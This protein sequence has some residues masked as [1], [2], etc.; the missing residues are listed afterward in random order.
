MTDD[1]AHSLLPA[2]YALIKWRD[3]RAAI[4]D[5]IDTAPHE[6]QGIP[7]DIARRFTDAE[8]KLFEEACGL[9]WFEPRPAPK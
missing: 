9:N 7:S 1:A 3:A 8:A 6:D 4:L 5:C 2:L